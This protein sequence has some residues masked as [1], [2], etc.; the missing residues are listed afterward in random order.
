MYDAARTAEAQ[1]QRARTTRSRV[2]L[3]RVV[4]LAVPVVEQHLDARPAPSVSA[5]DRRQQQPAR[6]SAPPSASRGA[7]AQSRFKNRDPFAR[8]ESADHL[9]RPPPGFPPL[10]DCALLLDGL[11]RLSLQRLSFRG[12]RHA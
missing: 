12:T 6:A 5:D 9:G 2:V 8:P 4:E 11:R 3:Q 1:Q 10:L 7:S